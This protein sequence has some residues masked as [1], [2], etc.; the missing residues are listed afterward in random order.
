M[1]TVQ[2]HVGHGESS[3]WVCLSGLVLL[4]TMVGSCEYNVVITIY[5]LS[6]SHSEGRQPTISSRLAPGG[7]Y[8]VSAL[9]QPSLVSVHTSN[10]Y[11]SMAHDASHNW[12]AY[13][14]FLIQKVK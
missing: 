14:S 12:S 2:S 4:H 7:N 10:I 5:L 6:T 13:C 9:N 3:M 1:L 8:Q 11:L